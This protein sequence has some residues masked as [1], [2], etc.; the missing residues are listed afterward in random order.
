[1]GSITDGQPER[2]GVRARLGVGI[3]VVLGVVAGFFGSIFG[4]FS[5]ML[6]GGILTAVGGIAAVAF[7]G[8]TW[9]RVVLAVGIA[10]VIG[11]CAYVLIGL[12]MPQGAGSGSGGGC[13]PGGTCRP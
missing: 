3:A 13:E 5:V 9:T 10:V 11:A 1:M 6:A 8:R 2:R 7:R 12:V 4:P